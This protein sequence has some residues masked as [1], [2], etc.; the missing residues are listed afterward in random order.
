MNKELHARFSKSARD[1]CE[2]VSVK[3]LKDFFKINIRENRIPHYRELYKKICRKNRLASLMWGEFSKKYGYDYDF[4]EF[5]KGRIVKILSD[6]S[7]VE[8]QEP[9]MFMRILDRL[10]DTF[11]TEKDFD[12]EDYPRLEKILNLISYASSFFVSWG[13]YI[14]SYAPGRKIITD[15]FEKD[16]ITPVIYLYAIIY[17][18]KVTGGYDDLVFRENF[19][20]LIP[21]F[22]PEKFF[23]EFA[24]S[25]TDDVDR[26]N[27]IKSKLALI[28]LPKLADYLE[29]KIKEGGYWEYTK[30]MIS[31]LRY[32]V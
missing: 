18:V 22:L 7:R 1:E 3:V 15:L 30:M 6:G 28:I 8:I 31:K 23:S 21:V 13:D 25:I 19:V 14:L 11:I 32:K 20:K 4:A 27:I 17:A 12:I 24:A 16:S 2:K 9:S 26:Q 29:R 5:K 10:T